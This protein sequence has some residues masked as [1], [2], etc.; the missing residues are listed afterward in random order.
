[1]AEDHAVGR[2]GPD[3]GGGWIVSRA[4]CCVVYTETRVPQIWEI[5]R[6]DRHDPSRSMC[7]SMS[8]KKVSR[9]GCQGVNI[10]LK[11]AGT[12]QSRSIDVD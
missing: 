10:G 5:E 8:D 6:A 2:C 4:C 12:D 1:M 9:S 7:S 3:F 11:I